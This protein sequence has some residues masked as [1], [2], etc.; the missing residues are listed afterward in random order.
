MMN[1]QAVRGT[2]PQVDLYIYK[3]LGNERQRQLQRGDLQRCRSASTWAE[4]CANNSYGAST[5]PGSTV[6]AAFDNAAAAGV[7][8]VAS[9]GNSGA[10]ANTVGFPAQYAS[11]MAVAADRLQ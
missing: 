11:V 6:K 3:V 10:G 4:R 5:D 9:A 1:S 7:I 8:H 2:A